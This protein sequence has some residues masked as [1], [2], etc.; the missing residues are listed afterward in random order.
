MN[1]EKVLITGA[2]GMLGS[3][4][5]KLITSKQIV[6]YTSE[7]DITNSEL[8]NEK[9]N[10]ENPDIIIHTAAYTD[11]EDSE[12]NADR[13]YSVNT[14]G[15]QN[16]VNYC[17]DKNILFIYISSTGVYGT[18]KQDRYTE[19]DD[20]CPTTIHHKS[21]YEAEKI[22]QNHLSKYLIVRTGWLYGGDKTH[23]K[24]FVYK[25]FLEA[26]NNDTIYSNDTQIGNPT[27]VVDLAKQ[28]DVLIEKKQY[29]IF[30]CVNEAKSISR[31]DYVKKIVELFSLNC[32]VNIAPEDSF[33]RVAPVSNNESAMNYKL[34]L[35]DLNVMGDW[36]K[37]LN[38][39]ITELKSTF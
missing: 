2:S 17:I 39:Y 4:L 18:A 1:G 3:N 29:G 22:V 13:A 24:N 37:S 14:I 26:S 34:D 9:L 21:K 23:S 6:G 36:K 35:L 33:K 31:Y 15:T 5:M 28:I 32:S 7:L 27:S 25:R 38:N 12:V 30:N 16:L 10:L 20:V 11:V 19:F 8:I